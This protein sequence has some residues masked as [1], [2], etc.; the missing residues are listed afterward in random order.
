MPFSTTANFDAVHAFVDLLKADTSAARER[1]AAAQAARSHQ[2][3][4]TKPPGALGRLET[5]A[6]FLAR[7]QRRSIPH[8]RA[9]KTLV[10]AGNHGIASRGVSPYPAEVTAQMV[11]NFHA[12]G[13]AINQLCALGGAQLQ[14]IPIALETPTA[15]F[16]AGPA[17]TEAETLAA[18]KDGYMAVTQATDLLL[19]GEMGIGNTTVAA[20]LVAALIGGPAA[21]W[22]GVGTGAGD[23]M[24]AQKVALVEAGLARHRTLLGDPLA[25]LA[26]F[27]GRE[28]AAMVGALLAARY[29]GIPVLLD[30]YVSTAAALIVQRLGA[31]LIDNCLAGHVSA[32][33]GHRR[34][35]A[36]L[37]LEPILDLGMRLGEG[38]GAAVALNILRAAVACHAGMATFED[39]GVSPAGEGQDAAP[40]LPLTGTGGRGT[41]G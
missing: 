25:V 17:M 18:L 2:D 36:A 10:F 5:L 3:R 19:I 31:G 38:S 28:Q 27:G 4:L 20:A 30:G 23:A 33:R 37:E 9:V 40:E 21:D 34:L 6:V 39:A 8:L 29:Y 1:V 24:Q 22:V 41:A 16:T 12:G 11:A 14:V 13:A 35:L 15:D 7:W 32:E 26:A